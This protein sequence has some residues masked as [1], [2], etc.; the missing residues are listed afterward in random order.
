MKKNYGKD[1]ESHF[2][3]D[4]K[5]T[6][7]GQ[8]ILRLKDDTSGYYGNSS[9][10]CDFLTHVDTTLF[11]LEVKCHYGN[12][13][14]WSDFSQYDELIKYKGLKNVQI[15]LIVWFIDHD[16]IIFVD[17]DTITKMKNDGMKSI[18]RR[19]IDQQGY[20]YTEIP[21]VKKRVFLKSDYSCMRE[22]IL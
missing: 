22:F 10:P 3:A 4:W 21:S 1:F 2:K 14:P 7:P 8:F 20:K 19:L 17:I 13:F 12:T 16:S 6:F 11:M 15:G 18:N 5:E 9:N